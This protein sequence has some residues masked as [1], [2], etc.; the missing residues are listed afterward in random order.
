MVHLPS[1]D[2]SIPNFF[3]CRT[4]SLVLNADRLEID[5]FRLE[6]TDRSVCGVFVALGGNNLPGLL[7]GP[8]PI[9]ELRLHTLV[10]VGLH[11]FHRVLHVMQQ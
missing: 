3:F 6:D 5:P 7:A 8:F 1:L 2:H 9:I 11:S 4:T 10:F